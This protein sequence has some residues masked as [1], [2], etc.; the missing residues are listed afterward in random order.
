M[1]RGEV[2]TL[3]KI[4]PKALLLDTQ[5]RV[6][7]LFALAT[8]ID[9]PLKIAPIATAYVKALDEIAT[10]AGARLDLT[11]TVRAAATLAQA[12]ER[13]DTLPR[14]TD[15]R[16]SATMNAFLVRLTHSL[17]STLYTK[18]GRFDQDPAATV[19]LLPLLARARELPQLTPDSDAYGFL[20]TELL[21]GRN[22]VE[23]TLR[24]SAQ[25]IVHFLG[26]RTNATAG[27]ASGRR[28]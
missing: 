3:D 15:A 17:N 28:E 4:D 5:Y 22:A 12:A 1:P 25:Q 10:A 7:Q 16:G 21:R 9:L 20:E 14:P 2:D 6:A 27:S 13:L 23:T 19:P 11:S 24:E 26:A 18:A 8:A